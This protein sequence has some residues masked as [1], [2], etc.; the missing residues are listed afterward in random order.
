M[1]SAAS[2][3]AARWCTIAVFLGI[4]FSQASDCVLYFN[5]YNGMK[6]RW[7]EVC[8][9]VS[10]QK[11][12]GEIFLADEGD[13]AQYYL[14]KE[15]AKWFGEFEEEA[16]AS[17]TVGSPTFPPPAVRGV[18]YAFYLTD[19]SLNQKPPQVRSYILSHARLVQLYPLH[20][21]P[22]DRTLALFHQEMASI[23]DSRP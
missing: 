22:K 7:K 15:N 9:E 4:G 14:G 16:G 17:G 20:Y 13:V 21:G 8:Q 18:W 1:M 23:P 2:S 5:F 12:P 10:R 3:N 6:P 19:S 11:L